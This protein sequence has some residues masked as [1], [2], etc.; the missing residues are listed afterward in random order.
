M[1][2]WATKLS[3]LRV[4]FLLGG[5]A[6]LRR[7]NGWEI[8]AVGQKE[9]GKMLP[10]L[11]LAH[12]MVYKMRRAQLS[13]MNALN[14][15]L[16][17]W[18]QPGWSNE[19]SIIPIEAGHTSACLWSN[20]HSLHYCTTGIGSGRNS[21]SLEAELHIGGWGCSMQKPWDGLGIGLAGC[22]AS[23]RDAS[24]PPHRLDHLLC[25]QSIGWSS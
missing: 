9:N 2:S 23:C 20:L 1:L 4:N 17:S 11:R 22:L 12:A 7:G 24:P 3:G 14:R 5:W 18:G 6:N 15:S 19:A 25:L 10:M 13:L 16:A 21:R 8:N